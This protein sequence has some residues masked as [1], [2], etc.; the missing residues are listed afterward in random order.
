MLFTN[1]SLTNSKEVNLENALSKGII[2]K[3][4]T[5]ALAS[6]SILSSIVLNNFKSASLCNTNLG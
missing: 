6:K 1:I 5:P 3:W 2:T 4:S